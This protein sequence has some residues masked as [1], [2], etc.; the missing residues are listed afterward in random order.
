M[1]T[2]DPSDVIPPGGLPPAYTE[3][4]LAEMDRHAKKRQT[5][6]NRA[7]VNRDRW[8]LLNCFIDDGMAG[9]EYS[10]MA[11]WFALFRYAKSDGAATVP[12]AHLKGITGCGDATLK[13]ALR[14]LINA[15]WIDR[16][17]R[18]G[19]IGGVAAYYVKTPKKKGVMMIPRGGHGDTT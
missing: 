10:D 18:G 13:R 19:P 6:M 12:R 2:I 8:H 1:M 16:I 14:R 7:K 15:G 11:V 3:R 9:L 17:R 4:E 5:H